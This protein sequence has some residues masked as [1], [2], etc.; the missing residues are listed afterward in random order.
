MIDF[1]RI[2][3]HL[4][5]HSIAFKLTIE[6]KLKAFLIGLSYLPTDVKNYAD[7][8]FLDIFPETTRQVSE[9][10]KQ[11]GL[12]DSG[13]TES[14]RRIRLDSYWKD[15]G[16]Q[17]PKYIQDTL[18]ANGFDVYIHEWWEKGTQASVNI[19]DCTIPRN[20]L[21]ILSED[22]I[23][24][25]S[26]QCNEPLS[27]SGET[28]VQCG[29]ITGGAGYALV[30]KVYESAIIEFQAGETLSQCGEIFAQCG[31]ILGYGQKYKKYTIPNDVTKFPYFLYIGGRNF[32]DL[33]I[34]ENKRKDEFENL[35]LKIAPAQQWVGI[36]VR[37]S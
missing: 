32:G 2:I 4:L 24:K 5:P 19:K 28:F 8:I 20:P 1:F 36:L 13:L 9:W 12:I 18:Q 21:A 17:S 30:N 34:I 6:N 22:G 35:I 27:Q 25:F 31:E 14:Q 26:I 16:G 7:L 15:K 3:E 33:A 11:F 23:V 29:E 37:Y 10:E